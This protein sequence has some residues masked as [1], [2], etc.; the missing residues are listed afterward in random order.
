MS[1][2]ESFS[3]TK[4]RIRAATKKSQIAIFAVQTITGVVFNVVFAST[5][6]TSRKIRSGTSDFVGCYYGG[7]GVDHARADMSRFKLID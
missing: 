5:V 6:Q 1:V 4:E 2:N 3:V 7:A